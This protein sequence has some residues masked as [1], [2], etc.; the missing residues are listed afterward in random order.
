MPHAINGILGVKT[1]DTSTTKGFALG[2]S[3]DMSDGSCYR[4]IEADAALAA[5]AATAAEEDFG[6]AELTTTISGAEPNKV[7]IPQVAVASGSF[8]WGLE[9]GLGSV[10]ALASCVED[11]KLYTTA[12]AGA[13][14]D[15]ATDLIQGLRL[16]ATN[17]GSTAAT[18]CLATTLMV[19]NAQD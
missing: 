3:V 6:C 10:L 13:I 14:D 19:T 2:A 1:T 9:T 16:T 8:G 15:T 4:Y 5:Y 11:V 12:T 17:G 18:A 7:L